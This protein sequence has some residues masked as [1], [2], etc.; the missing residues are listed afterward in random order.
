MTNY[1]RSRGGEKI[2]GDTGKDDVRYKGNQISQLPG[3]EQSHPIP[4]A[5]RDP[6]TA[7]H[8]GCVHKFNWIGFGLDCRSIWIGSDSHKIQSAFTNNPD[9]IFILCH[10]QY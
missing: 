7:G 2:V 8:I 10:N 3:I 5:S 4:A 9:W 1:L 6:P